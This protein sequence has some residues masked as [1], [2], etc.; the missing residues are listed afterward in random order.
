M[1]S[2]SVI[3]ATAALTSAGDVEQATSWVR[4]GLG[5]RVDVERDGQGVLVARCGS[6]AAYRLLGVWARSSWLPLRARFEPT[7]YQGATQVTV[8]LASDQGWYLVTTSLACS[9]YRVRFE[10]LVGDLQGAG[11]RL[12]GPVEHGQDGAGVVVR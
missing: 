5:W 12:F 11:L 3:T 6:R 9:A 4:A 8:S 1:S 2:P 10:Q 7:A